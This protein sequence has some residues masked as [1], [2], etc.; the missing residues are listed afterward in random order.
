MN[1][2]DKDILLAILAIDSYNQ[3]Y[4]PGLRQFNVHEIGEATVDFELGNISENS[5]ITVTVY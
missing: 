1:T 2:A 5:K 3:G 4:V